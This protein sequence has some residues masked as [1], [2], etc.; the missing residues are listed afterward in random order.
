MPDLKDLLHSEEAAKLMGNK[1]ALNAIQKAPE[2]RQLLQ[3]LSRNAGG[4]LEGAANAAAQGDSAALMR[5][6]SALLND[7]EGKKLLSQISKTMGK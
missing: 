1:D 7:P 4:D 6:M 3:M 5:A 2:T